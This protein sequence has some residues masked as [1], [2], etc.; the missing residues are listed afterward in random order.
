MIRIREHSR[1]DINYRVDWLNN[2]KVNKFLGD[3]HAKGT[4]LV[5]QKK[6]FNDYEKARNK[7]FFTICDED[8]PI[9][10]I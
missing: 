6:R 10:L 2:P 7:K 9:G 3:D 1:E 8:K 4:T 5:K